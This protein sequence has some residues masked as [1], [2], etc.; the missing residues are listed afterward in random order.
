MPADPVYK[1]SRTWHCLE[2]PGDLEFE[3][4]EMMNHMREIHGFDPKTSKGTREMIMHLDGSGFYASTYEII[5]N[6][7]KFREHRQAERIRKK[8]I[9]E[10]ND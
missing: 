1:F 4:P 2:C 8:K 9:K 10:E 7:L 6:G 5:I 3:H